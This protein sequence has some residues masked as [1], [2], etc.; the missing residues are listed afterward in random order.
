M[1]QIIGML[2]EAKEKLEKG[3]VVNTDLLKFLGFCLQNVNRTKSQNFQDLWA[4]YECGAGY[5]VERR[6]FIEFGSTN[7]ID[8]SNT[9]LLEREH[10]WTGI[11]AEPNPVYHEIL[12]TNRIAPVD[13]RCV[14]KTTGEK[15]DFLQTEAA[16][17][18]TITSYK[19]LDYNAGRRQTGTTIQVE[20]V[21]LYD[22]LEQHQLPKHIQYISV[23]TEGSELDIITKFFEQN[24]DKY[25][26]QC[27]TIEHNFVE[28]QRKKI[29][30]LMIRNGYRRKFTS[31]SRWDDFFLKVT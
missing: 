26:V 11:L 20:T 10:Y 16:D 9:Y 8:G 19:D 12:K 2:Y 30:E 27:W 14:Y 28:E 23:D 24:N 22:L 7:G 1:D 13:T 3:E 4:L 5:E 17:L 31:I 6:T 21:T 29:F 18:S 25:N 15:I